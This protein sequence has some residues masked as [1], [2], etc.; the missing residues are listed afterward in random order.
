MGKIQLYK[1]IENPTKEQQAELA[2][3]EAELLAL[4]QKLFNY[5]QSQGF[6]AGTGQT[7]SND[8]FGLLK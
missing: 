4:Q 5:Y 7:S 6:G 8:P 3:F 2:K 1:G